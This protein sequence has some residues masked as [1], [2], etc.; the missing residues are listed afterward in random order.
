MQQISEAI[1]R[2]SLEGISERSKIDAE[3]ERANRI[4]ARSPEDYADRIAKRD[5]KL[6]R[7]AV[8]AGHGH[9]D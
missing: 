7:R 4:R 3:K 6:A 5:A 9:A 8:A 1:V 2:G